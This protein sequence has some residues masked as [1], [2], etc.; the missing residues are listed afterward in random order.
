MK[1]CYA[2][3]NP[4]TSREHVPP[5][6]LFPE[7]KD[8]AGGAD[9]RLNLITVPSCADHNLHKAGDD[10]YFLYVL[11]LSITSN[12]IAQEQVRTKLAR[13]INRRPALVNS[14]LDCSEDCHVAD[15]AT[16][17]IHEAVQ[18]G[19]DG[20]R[21]QKTLE[22]VARGI[23]CHHFNERWD[24]AL[25]V[26]ADWVAFPQEPN[27]PE[28]DANR[29]VLATNAD[30]LFLNTP[31]QATS[32]DVFWYQVHEPPERLRCLIRLGFYGDSKACAFFGEMDVRG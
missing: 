5:K 18:V 25:R 31:K 4:A 15:S 32:P 13:A 28:I 8:A 1:S 14:I 19:L 30:K 12:A 11:S 7:Q 22:L 6:C 26:H 2:C 23:Y 10:E 17:Q 21:F 16:G 3:Q 24:G 20:T 27:A 29:V 9:L